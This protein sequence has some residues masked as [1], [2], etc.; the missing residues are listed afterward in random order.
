M[1][2]YY[3][4]PDNPQM[5]FDNVVMAIRDPSAE[6]LPERQRFPR[7]VS[8]VELAEYTQFLYL[9]AMNDKFRQHPK[10]RKMEVRCENR[11]EAE[12]LRQVINRQ[13]A[14]PTNRFDVTYYS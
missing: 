5:T 2:R 4:N 3:K 10:R 12:Y 7:S 11:G 1:A 8:D 6:Q 9:S 14:D 13:C